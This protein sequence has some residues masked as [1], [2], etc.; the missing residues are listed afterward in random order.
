MSGSGGSGGGYGPARPSRRS[1]RDVTGTGNGVGGKDAVDRCLLID[2]AVRV[3]SPQPS[4]LGM[5]SEGQA[6]RLR[7]TGD[8]P[9][10]LVVTEAGATAGSVIP[11][12][13]QILVE[14]MQ[15]GHQYQAVVQSIKGG[16]CIV[17][18]TP[19]M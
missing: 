7:L 6:L 13:L 17:R 19:R 15:S 14:C 11:S 16:I 12:S 8:G 4:V 9:P 2:E 10:V 1:T 3:S 18:I 5:L